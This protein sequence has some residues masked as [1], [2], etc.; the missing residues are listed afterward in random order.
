MNGWDGP[1]FCPFSECF[2]SLE[3]EYLRHALLYLNW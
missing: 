1:P 3:I 2:F